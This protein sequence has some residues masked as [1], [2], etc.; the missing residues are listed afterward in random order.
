MKENFYELLGITVQAS[1][2]QIKSAAVKLA[3]QYNPKD[4]P[5]DPKVNAQFHQIKLAY[6]TLIDLEKRALYDLSLKK[7]VIP[8]KK[9]KISLSFKEELPEITQEIH[10]ETV[11]HTP[12]LGYLLALFSIAVPV[13]L[14]MINPTLLNHY[15][16][17]ITFLQDKS[18]QVILAFQLLLG[19]GSLILLYSLFLQF[20]NNLHWFIYLIAL[21]II[22][23]TSYLLFL[24]PSLV[25]EYAHQLDWLRD[26]SVQTRLALQILLGFGLFLLSYAIFLQ[27]QQLSQ[28]SG[29]LSGEVIIYRASIHWII[30]LI[31]LLFIGMSGYCLL[32]DPV[33]LNN[34]LSEI[35]FLN[36]RSEQIE[37]GLKMILGIA[38]W[39]FLYALYRK[40]TLILVITS[41]RTLCQSGFLFKKRM[42]IE[43]SNVENVGLD[44]RL[45]GKILFYGT[46]DV[47]GTNSRGLSNQRIKIHHV[48]FPKK[49]KDILLRSLKRHFL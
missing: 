22:L 9:D 26:K 13:Y 33:F 23:T 35:A 27:I 3:R 2:E 1:P 19:F 42:E 39:S 47:R 40:L 7:G 25:T 8:D 20:Q 45:F 46:I 48:A 24:N 4:H 6:A 37:L 10:E 21:L 15:V 32:I 28:E 16:T 36:D 43:H 30:Y 31:P 44:Q 49:F 29:L 5:N 17:E 18:S 14:L 12:W 11:R 41:K 34:Y 38:I